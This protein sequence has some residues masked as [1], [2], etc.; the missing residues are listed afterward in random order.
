MLKARFLLLLKNVELNSDRTRNERDGDTE[1]DE[2][3]LLKSSPFLI[4]FLFLIVTVH[5]VI[6]LS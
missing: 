5:V 3:Q 6:A 4:S 1:Y 2:W